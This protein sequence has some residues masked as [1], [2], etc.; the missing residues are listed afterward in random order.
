MKIEEKQEEEE[1]GQSIPRITRTF[2]CTCPKF[3]LLLSYT[4]YYYK[5][6][7]KAD[8]L[9]LL[10]EAHVPTPII[11]NFRSSSAEFEST[12]QILSLGSVSCKRV[13]YVF[14]LR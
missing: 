4:T 7:S 3:W 8:I 12:P 5:H 1:A 14:F 9:L 11:V 6:T 2:F 13:V 10:T